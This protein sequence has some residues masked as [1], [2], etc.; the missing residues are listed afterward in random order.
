VTLEVGFEKSGHTDAFLSLVLCSFRFS[1]SPCLV[2]AY[3]GAAW[4]RPVGRES[5]RTLDSTPQAS[6]CAIPTGQSDLDYHVFL[7]SGV[8][9]AGLLPKDGRPFDERRE[10]KDPSNYFAPPCAANG[11]IGVSGVLAC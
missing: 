5:I 4:R 2:W 11:E 1:I 7:A 10:S 3:V 9:L 8:R 6:L